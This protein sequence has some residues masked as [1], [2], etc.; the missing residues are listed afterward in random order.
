VDDVLEDRQ[1]FG[2]NIRTQS[3][4]NR[5]YSDDLA[6]SKT[7]TEQLRGDYMSFSA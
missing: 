5:F 1:K 4:R 7:I 2:G 6:V 3:V